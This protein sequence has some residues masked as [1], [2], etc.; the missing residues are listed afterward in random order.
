MKNKYTFNQEYFKTIDTEE[1]AYILGFLYADGNLSNAETDKHYR[2]RL[3]LKEE[4]GKILERI[5]KE[6]E[7]TGPIHYRESKYKNP[8]CASYRKGYKIAQLE[9]NSKVLHKQLYDLGVVPNK[10]FKITYPNIPKELNRHFIRGFFDGDGSIYLRKNRPNG[11]RVN[12]TCASKKFL[13]TVANILLENTT[14]T[15]CNVCQTK[16]MYRIDKD[17]NNAIK[18]LDWLYGNSKIYLERK[19]ELYKELKAKM[20]LKAETP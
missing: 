1:K 11:F 3:L 4:D 17:K 19:Y 18:I 20:S 12:I 14:I 9:I 5:K 6:I 13:S 7:Y 16:N 10:T 15:N 8:N 2:V